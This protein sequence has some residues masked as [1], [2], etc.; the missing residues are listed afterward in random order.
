MKTKQ[1]NIE[2]TKTWAFTLVELLVTIAIVG[3][4][5]SLLLTVLARS[6]TKVMM[7][8]SQN[9]LKQ[10]TSQ[11]TVYGNDNESNYPHSKDDGNTRWARVMR[12]ELGTETMK[13]PA[14]VSNGSYANDSK[15]LKTEHSGSIIES[16]ASSGTKKTAVK[17]PVTV[18]EK[19]PVKTVTKTLVANP[20]IGLIYF[21]DCS[22]SSSRIEGVLNEGALLGGN[23]HLSSV[24]PGTGDSFSVGFWIKRMNQGGGVFEIG[25]SHDN[26][27]TLSLTEDGKLF[28][29]RINRVISSTPVLGGTTK[30]PLTAV[31]VGS[32]PKDEWTHVFLQFENDTKVYLNN[33]LACTARF[34]AVGLGGAPMKFGLAGATDLATVSGRASIQASPVGWGRVTGAQAIDGDR[35]TIFHGDEYRNHTFVID[36]GR[37]RKVSEITM[38]EGFYKTQPQYSDWVHGIINRYGLECSS[39]GVNYTSVFAPYQ[40]DN[41]LVRNNAYTRTFPE[42]TA[43]YW[44]VASTGRF[45]VVTFTSEIELWAESAFQG[46]IDEVRVYDRPLNDREIECLVDCEYDPVYDMD[47]V[48]KTIIRSVTK[49]ITKYEYQKFGEPIES[50]YSINAWAQDGHPLAKNNWDKFYT[51]WESGSSDTPIFTEGIWADVMPRP[52]DKAP[53]NFLGGDSGMSRICI[54]RYGNRA[55]NV[56]FFDGSVRSVH[57]QNLWSL[58][59]HQDWKAPVKLPELPNE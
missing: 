7:L 49:Y 14:S 36:L 34:N 11:W 54:D 13:S 40:L 10:I 52:T 25:S 23:G 33:S 47:Y 42:V 27:L 2:T 19:V 32:V 37:P 38:L 16:W 24:V 1:Y 8:A 43:R 20:R 30:V 58:Q 18:Q 26:R 41:R 22:K 46:G 3:I 55:N 57:L 4:L 39:D 9:N 17:V 5:A 31:L 51:T 6:K 50:S 56:A 29:R 12:R 59:W 44:R 21:N 48:I 28:I 15:K 45:G 53:K 35:V